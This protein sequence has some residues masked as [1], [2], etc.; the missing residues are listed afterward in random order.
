MLDRLRIAMERPGGSVE[1][2]TA[3]KLRY[4]TQ[5]A[6]V[7]ILV[8]NF[9]TPSVFLFPIPIGINQDINAAFK[10]HQGMVVEVGMNIKMAAIRN[11]V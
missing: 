3:V 1:Y 7:H 4:D 11:L 6:V 9:E 8:P 2:N 10:V 5:A